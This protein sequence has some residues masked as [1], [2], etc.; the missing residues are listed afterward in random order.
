MSRNFSILL[1]KKELI[2]IFYIK[3]INSST[4]NPA[5]RIMDLSVPLAIS[6]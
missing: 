2:I 4:V 6:L 1:E 3:S 5:S